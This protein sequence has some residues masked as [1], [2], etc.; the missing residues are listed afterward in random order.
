MWCCN[1]KLKHA[2]RTLNSNL[3]V[4]RGP[5]KVLSPNKNVAVVITF[6]A[7]KNIRRNSQKSMGSKFGLGNLRFSENDIVMVFRLRS[8]V[9]SAIKKRAQNISANGSGVCCD[10]TV[11]KDTF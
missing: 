2:L 10:P 11:S 1:F 5:H 8:P 6:G 9:G 4:V 7:T 3:E